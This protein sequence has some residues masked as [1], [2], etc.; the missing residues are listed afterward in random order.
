MDVQGHTFSMRRMFVHL[1]NELR[2]FTPAAIESRAVEKANVARGLL[3]LLILS[4]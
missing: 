4:V 2:D 1:A 3:C